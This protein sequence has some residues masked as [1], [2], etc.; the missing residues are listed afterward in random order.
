MI[1]VSFSSVE[2]A[3]FNDATKYDTFRLQGTKN[4]PFRFLGDIQYR[5]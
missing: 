2:D 1:L 4:L 5:Y 3:L